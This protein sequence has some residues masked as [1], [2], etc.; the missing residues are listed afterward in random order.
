MSVTAS[1][2]NLNEAVQSSQM[3]RKNYIN[4]CHLDCGK[5]SFYLF[6]VDVLPYILSVCPTGEVR[7]RR[8]PV[9]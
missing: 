7:V 8:L 9:I 4:Q 2:T 1:K 6:T 5:I 3:S